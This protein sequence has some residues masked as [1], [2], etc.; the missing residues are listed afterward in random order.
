MSA[1]NHVGLRDKYLILTAI[2]LLATFEF[3]G[4]SSKFPPVFFLFSF[5]LGVKFC[6]IV[7]SFNGILCFK[8]FFLEKINPTQEIF[9]LISL[10]V[11]SWFL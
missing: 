6:T 7:N 11:N 4:P 5:F 2:F 9:G 1:C 8:F 10:D 3:L